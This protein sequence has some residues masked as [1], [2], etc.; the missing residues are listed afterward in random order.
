MKDLAAVR[1][2]FVRDG[3]LYLDLMYDSGTMR[4]AR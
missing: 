4:F 2:A 1:I 3:D